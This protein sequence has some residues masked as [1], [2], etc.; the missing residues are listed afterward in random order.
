ML[1][2]YARNYRIRGN[3]WT[4]AFKYVSTRNILAGRRIRKLESTY[5]HIMEQVTK[6]LV[7]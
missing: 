3:M 7:R 4:R 1:E 6:L 5:S 2:N